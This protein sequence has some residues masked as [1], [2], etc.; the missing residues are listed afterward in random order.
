L[1][2]SIQE[3]RAV[4]ERRVAAWLAEDVPGY[5]ACWDDDLV[6]EMPGRTIRGRTAYE[7]LVRQSFAWARPRAFDVHHLA[8]DGDVAL[9][10]W[11][12]SVN[13]RSDE[14]VVEWRGMSAAELRNGRIVWWRE[15]YEDPEALAR[16]ARR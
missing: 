10:D 15:Y 4:F 8:V 14:A 7:E 3:A 11:T 12:I 2:L 13:R 6:I 9:A 1:A 16:A 5:L